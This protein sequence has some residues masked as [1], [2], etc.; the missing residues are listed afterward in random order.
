MDAKYHE[1]L[2]LATLKQLSDTR[3][4]VG[5]PDVG[6]RIGMTDSQSKGE[7]CLGH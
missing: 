6:S 2:V 4:D 1:F 3:A 5:K 7:K